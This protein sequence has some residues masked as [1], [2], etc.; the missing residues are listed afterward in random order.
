MTL[1][2]TSL[3][4]IF[5]F[6]AVASLILVIAFIFFRTPDTNAKEM[7][8]KYSSPASLFLDT[9]DARIHYRDEGPRDAP[10]LLLVHGGNASLHTWEA[11]V[12]AL[13]DRYRLISFDMP[14]H[15]LTGPSTSRDYSASALIK[16][17]TQVLDAAGVQRATW[18]GNS[19]GG[20]LV[21]RAGL[22]V[23]ER[24]N[25]LILLNAAGAEIGQPSKPYLGARLAQSWLGR[26]LMP[27][28]TPE[29]LVRKSV[30]QTVANPAALKDETVRRYW[31]LL[32]YPGNRQAAGDRFLVDREP[33]Q[34]KRIGTLKMPVL[35][36]WGA[37]DKV[38]PIVHGNAFA[39]AITGS[40]LIVIGNAGHLPMEETPSEVSKAI[41]LWMVRNAEP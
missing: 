19:L 11:V 37:Q 39:K 41:D 6:L 22:T 15:G 16:A 25:G 21:W 4:W 8:V 18:V 17:A 29:S 23:P 30:Q 2:E 27:H 38:I 13:D 26:Q 24:V 9:P 7:K 12:D 28:I 34:W 14:G 5:R 31:E 1:A 20:W 40:E 36:I 3:K 35:L 32:R 10:V 33:D